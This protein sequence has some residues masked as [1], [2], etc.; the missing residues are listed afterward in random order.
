MLIAL[1]ENRIRSKV[2]RKGQRGYCSK[3]GSE[4]IAKCGTVNTWHW[5][6]KAK[7][8]CDWY[9][10]ESEWHREWKS[11]FPSDKV[12]VYMNQNRA[13]AIDSTGRVWE[14]QNS[15]LGGEEINEREQVYRS[16]LWIWNV[17]G[18][19]KLVTFNNYIQSTVYEVGWYKIYNGIIYDK[20]SKKFT[21]WGEANNFSVRMKSYGWG[22][23][24]QSL[25]FI[26]F[27]NSVKYQAQDIY[28]EY[29]KNHKKSLWLYGTHALSNN[30]K[31]P[32]WL[33]DSIDGL[34]CR[35]WWQYNRSIQ[36]CKKPVVLDMNDNLFFAIS[37]VST[38]NIATFTDHQY[39]IR[40]QEKV[41]FVEGY[42]FE[43][44]KKKLIC[45]FEAPYSPKQLSFL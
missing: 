42:L 8:S 4:V 6:H 10:R 45:E 1:T 17:K 23:D 18:Q 9:S 30:P 43:I 14:F 26:D 28:A 19:Q 40:I 15:H 35:F 37:K 13:D 44:S 24:I 29:K 11:L 22:V 36:Q 5:A 2:Q 38:E 34:S 32:Q 25:H 16:L 39:G 41:L 3:C 31:K 12:E 20:S 21:S 33:P 27:Q 7:K